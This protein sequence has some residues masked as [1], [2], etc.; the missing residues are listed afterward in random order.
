MD[1]VRVC[2]ERYFWV[3]FWRQTNSP[4][5]T[6][7]SS[8]I[9]FP[10]WE[11][12]RRVVAGGNFRNICNVLIWNLLF[13]HGITARVCE[14]RMLLLLLNCCLL[15]LP[16]ATFQLDWRNTKVE[17]K[18]ERRR[19]RKKTFISTWADYGTA[20]R[21]AQF[22]T[23]EIRAVRTGETGSSIKH[24]H[25]SSRKKKE[26]FLAAAHKQRVWRSSGFESKMPSFPT[27]YFFYSLD[28]HFPPIIFFLPKKK[29]DSHRSSVGSFRNCGE[30][31]RSAWYYRLGTNKTSELGLVFIDLFESN[32]FGS[33]E[34]RKKL[35]R[36]TSPVYLLFFLNKGRKGI[37][38]QVHECSDI[39]FLV[40]ICGPESRNV[41]SG[42]FRLF[43]FSPFDR[44]FPLPPE[45]NP[46]VPPCSSLSFKSWA[47]LFSFFLFVVFFSSSSPFFTKF[48]FIFFLPSKF[49]GLF[50]SECVEMSSITTRIR[51]SYLSTT[52]LPFWKKLFSFMS[53]NSQWENQRK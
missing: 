38:H 48:Y 21:S 46:P 19:R 13:P 5:T 9:H 51:N 43:F 10:G 41:S 27:P 18:S 52:S 32:H 28:V 33:K 7:T 50:L 47:L 4:T 40:T 17:P 22:G 30:L 3:P 8:Y 23:D 2:A 29:T 53:S 15:L 11:R 49:P 6:A 36:H 14:T 31:I 39:F 20:A 37:D 45:G 34:K 42:V 35:S 16:V 24:H 44:K 12:G 25:H 26:I 1:G